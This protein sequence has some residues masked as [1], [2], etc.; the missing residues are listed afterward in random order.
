MQQMIDNAMS[1]NV[2][3][4]LKKLI[5][6]YGMDSRIYEVTFAD[7]DPSKFERPKWIITVR[8][9][10]NNKVISRFTQD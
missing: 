2:G 3:D 6:V 8:T 1:L 4:A 9:T 7:H 10:Y 5:E